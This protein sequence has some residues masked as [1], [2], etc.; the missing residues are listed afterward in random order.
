MIARRQADDAAPTCSTTPDPSWPST[1][2]NGSGRCPSRSTMSV[3]HTPTPTSRTTSSSAR[4]SSSTT[5][6][7]TG[8]APG[9]RKTAARAAVGMQGVL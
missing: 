1:T 9:W 5:G 3:W 4:G 8:G 7:I 6:S 2:G